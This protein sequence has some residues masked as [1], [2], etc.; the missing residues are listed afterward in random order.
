MD[1]RNVR[2]AWESFVEGGK[3]QP[4]VRDEVVESW[5]RSHSHKINLGQTKAE[6]VGEAELFRR[7]AENNAFM[8]ASRSALKNSR[9]FLAEAGSMMILTDKAGVIIETEGDQ[10]IMDF[11]HEI[12]AVR[13]GRWTESD[14]GT[15]GVGTTLALGRPIMI[16]GAEHFCPSFQSWTCA[17]SPVLHPVDGEVI[18]SVVIAGPVENFN[19]HSL[20]L[21]VVASEQVAAE[22]AREAQRDHEILLRH[23]MSKRA[24]WSSEELV[25]LDRR[26]MIVHATERALRNIERQ[27]SE[28]VFKGA[29]PVLKSAPFSSWRSRLGEVL[30]NA[31]VELVE[32][33]GDGVGAVLVL[34][35][36]RRKLVTGSSHL[37][38]E[39]IVDLPEIRGESSA[40]REAKQR[41]IQ[42]AASGAPILLTGETGVGK[43]LFA[44]AIHSVGA[45]TGPFVPVNC[46]GL[47]RELIASEFFGYAKGAFTGAREEGGIGKIEAAN[48][49]VLCLDEIGE[50][51]LELQTY[52]LRV[53]EDGI[54]YRV[55]SNEPRQVNIR[56]VAMTNRDLR[57]EVEAGRFRAD[58]FYRIAVLQLPIPAL[59]ER[60]EDILLLA[61]HFIQT[62]SQRLGRAAPGLSEEVKATLL[63]YPWPGN[64]RELR[65]AIENMLLLSGKDCIQISD[66]HPDLRLHTKTN[67]P[68]AVSTPVMLGQDMKS[69]ERVNIETVVRACDGNLTRAAKKLGIARSTLYLRL[70]SY[71]SVDASNA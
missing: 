30:P 53:L 1:I 63:R 59:R 17:G 5:K 56:L 66:L 60:G 18:G 61:E 7:Q 9:K 13:G 31:N 21:A 6:V 25:M 39:K 71:N 48:N 14:T 16:H 2:Q 8:H 55:G 57:A 38:R 35:N 70:A 52:L 15:N 12:H 68:C 26:G 28:V 62:I 19:P 67:M 46:G 54:I 51:P 10:R 41:T 47:P 33:N 20:A 32:Q 64:V 36:R 65:N 37:E 44:R 69:V 27:N 42:M 58:L 40:I 45:S 49:G 34:R 24:Q 43:E 29:M 11:G 4:G 23:F 22:A 3:P 50:L